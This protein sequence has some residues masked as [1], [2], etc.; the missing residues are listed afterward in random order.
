MN[1]PSIDEIRALGWR[2][3]GPEVM[4]VCTLI[5]HRRAYESLLRHDSPEVERLRDLVR[6]M[7][8]E[9]FDA[10]LITEEEYADLVADYDSGKRVARLEG[11]D[12]AKKKLVT[13]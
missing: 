10:R 1:G 7:R 5:N 8:S 13:K 4:A 12:A 6:Y 3:D 9:L 11:W 2:S